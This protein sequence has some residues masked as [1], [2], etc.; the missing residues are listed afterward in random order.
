MAHFWLNQNFTWG[1]NGRAA[2]LLAAKP[3]AEARPRSRPRRRL[4]PHGAIV[5]G[6]KGAGQLLGAAQQDPQLTRCVGILSGPLA[7]RVPVGGQ[8]G[9]HGASTT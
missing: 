5:A 4:V 8:L 7:P 3:P 2:G 6:G 1:A 9:A